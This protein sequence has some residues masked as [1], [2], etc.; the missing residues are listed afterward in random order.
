M[1]RR[2]FVKNVLAAGAGASFLSAGP[3]WAGSPIFSRSE[4]FRVG[5]IGANGMGWSNMNAFLKVPGVECTA[6]ADVDLAVRERRAADAEKLQGSRPKLFNDYRKMLEMKELD[7]VII[8]SPDHWHCLHL[9]DSLDAGKHAYCE[10]PLG[11][12][13]EECQV[14]RASAVRHPG[15]MVQVGQWQR[16][17]PHYRAA[18]DYLQSGKIG[19][20]RM[21]KTWSYVGWKKPLVPKADAPIPAG[22]DYDLWLGPAPRRPFNPNRFHFEFR[23]FWDYAGGL[24]TDWGVH[25][26]DIAFEG[27]NLQAPQ[28]VMASG[29]KFGYPDSAGETPDTMQTIYTFDRCNVA[30]E[31]VLGI[32]G[33]PYNRPEGIAFIGNDATL[34]VNRQGWAV[35]PEQET[36]GDGLLRYRSDKLPD[37]EKPANADYLLLHVRNFL[38]CISNNTP[39][40][41]NCNIEKAANVAINSCIGNIAQRLGRKVYWDTSAEAFL[42]DSEANQLMTADYQNGWRLPQ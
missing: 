9:C 20:V 37:Q 41:L 39:E 40:K 22:V 1:N 7:A 33:G 25:Q 10:K 19:K 35:L 23:W 27:L 42:N 31:H 28:S 4:K 30:W 29:G 26:L 5:L 17:G 14:M 8:G 6:I 34:V 32:S 18:L 15:L 36:T 13:I 11:R 2:K 24:M 16:S 38:D 3:L 21:V 12:T